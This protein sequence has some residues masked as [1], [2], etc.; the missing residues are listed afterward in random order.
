M[1]MTTVLPTP[2]TVADLTPEWLTAAL[3]SAG[4][5][6][7]ITAARVESIGAGVGLVATLH[8]L[9]MTG[10]GDAPPTLVVKLPS[11]A[12]SSRF[13]AQM[14]SMYRRE[15]GFYA[16]LS[17]RTPL[18]HPRCLY[19]DFDEATQNFVLLLE[20]LGGRTT[21]DQLEGCQHDVAVLA[22]RRLAEHHAAWWDDATLRATTWLPSINDAPLPEAVAYSFEQSWGATRELFGERL[23]PEITAL[24]ERFAGLVATILTRLAEPPATLSHGDYRLD[25][26]FFDDGDVALCDWQLVDRSRGGRDLGYFA[27]QSLRPDDRAA[28]ESELVDL[29]VA[30]LAAGGVVGYD[31]AAAWEDYRMSALLGLAYPVIATGS[32][33]HSDPRSYRLTGEMLDRAVRAIVELDCVALAG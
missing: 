20:D 6:G 15:V 2:S 19:A 18:A 23:P 10:T 9:T 27:T 7:T 24:G 28:W 25:N 29:Y 17:A 8:R 4:V 13:V 3:G 33:D 12:P 5:N 1:A 21:I 30:G 14:L 31:R 11:I 32:L 26:M 22:V 16:E